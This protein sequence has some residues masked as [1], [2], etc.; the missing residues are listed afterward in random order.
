MPHLLLEHVHLALLDLQHVLEVMDLP[1]ERAFLLRHL[2]DLLALLVQSGLLLLQAQAQGVHLVQ[3]RAQSIR[4]APFLLKCES[5]FFSLGIEIYGSL[6]I[7]HTV[8]CQ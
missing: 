5:R 7:L 6:T 8:C 3:E 4:A 2:L 1:V